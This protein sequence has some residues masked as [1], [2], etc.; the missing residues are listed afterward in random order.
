MAI[1]ASVISGGGDDASASL[2]SRD[3]L[4][5]RE[6]CFFGFAADFGAVFAAVLAAGLLFL[7]VFM[8]V[9]AG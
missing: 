7:A 6:A 3:D 8:W 5:A 4:V 2:R 1:S 9:L